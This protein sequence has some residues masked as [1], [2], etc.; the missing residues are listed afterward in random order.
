MIRNI[1]SSPV[2]TAVAGSSATGR[3]HATGSAVSPTS[4]APQRVVRHGFFVGRVYHLACN[5]VRLNKQTLGIRRVVYHC[6]LES[7]PA[8]SNSEFAGSW[9][10]PGETERPVGEEATEI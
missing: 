9:C 3:R 7:G 10:F 4:V 8:G 6:F 1:I 2:H 5:Q